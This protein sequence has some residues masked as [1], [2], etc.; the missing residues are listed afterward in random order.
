MSNSTGCTAYWD[1]SSF[2]IVV[3]PDET[4][5]GEDLE[6]L[7]IAVHAWNIE[8]GREVFVVVPGLLN[9]G[10]YETDGIQLTQGAL[11][12][13]FLGLCPVV[14]H[15]SVDGKLGRVWRGVCTIDKEAI[16]DRSV[17]A[18]VV[19]HELG[20]ALGFTHTD[21]VGAL[22]YPFISSSLPAASG[23]DKKHLDTV[24]DMM[25]G[26]YKSKSL[27]GLTSCL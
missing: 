22:M 9:Q 18:R 20:H 11:R 10:Y 15:P 5:D 23:F 25:D 8:V 7:G 26:T 3:P 4:F 14:Y 21:D 6:F 27:A 12:D 24:R 2:P 19:M 16:S 1:Q 17:Y 13:P